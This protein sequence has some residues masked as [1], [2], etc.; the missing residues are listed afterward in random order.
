LARDR[1]AL[2]GYYLRLSSV[3]P[4]SH[5]DVFPTREDEL[6]YWINAYNAAVLV[7]VLEYYPMDSVRDVKAP[8]AL[9]PFL[10]GKMRLAGFFYFQDV[11]LGGERMNLYRLEN[12]IIR[13]YGEPR[14]HFAVNCAS[15]GCPFLPRNAFHPDTLDSE[16]DREARRFFASPDK[17]RIDH[18]AGV[19]WMSSILD[20][21][22]EDFGKDLLAYVRRYVT[23]ERR[24][25]LDRAVAYQLRFLEY[26]WRLN[27]Q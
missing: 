4:T 16:L 13:G 19:V 25:E 12:E 14:I 6:A 10:F 26:D 11:I 15:V 18:E 24:A 5:P 9:R 3:S 22:R 20:W 21:Y 7:A 1:V 8:V 27:R 17:L 2:D 23:P